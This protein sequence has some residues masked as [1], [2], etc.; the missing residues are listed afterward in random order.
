MF[1]TP[2]GQE[3][4][5]IFVEEVYEEVS[6]TDSRESFLNTEEKEMIKKPEKLL[7]ASTSSGGL[8][9]IEKYT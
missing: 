9:N 6:A 1:Q 3:E 5:E 8:P 4:E 2:M 7:F